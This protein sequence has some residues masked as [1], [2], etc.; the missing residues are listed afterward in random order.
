MNKKKGII[1]KMQQDIIIFAALNFLVLIFS[2]LN[3]NFIDRYNIMSMVQSFV[4]Y[5]IM[6][7]G[8]T[9][10]VA[11]GGIDLSIGT[12]CIAS[13]VI[14]GK[15][16]MSGMPLGLTI[17]VMIL[18]GLIFGIINGLMVSRLKLPAFIATLGTMMIARGASALIAKNPNIF[19]PTGTWYN[20]VFSNA[21][22][23]PIGIIWVL[24]FMMLG[25]Y[26][27]YKTKV[28]RYILAIGSN[29]EA[30]NLSGINTKKYK[31][32]AYILSGICAGIAGIFW[33]SSF[34]TIVIGSGNG[35]ELDVIAG[36]Y[37]GGTSATGGNASILGSVIGSFML[38]VIRSGLNFVL[39]KFNI[40]MNSTYVT[41]VL[42]GI[43]VVVAVILDMIKKRKPASVKKA[44]SKK[45][46][47]ILA[48]IASVLIIAIIVSTIIVFGNSNKDKVIAIVA[49]GETHAFWQ[50]VEKGAQDAATKYGYKITFR[51]PPSE[52]PANLPI[53]FEMV[54]TGLSNGSKG[55]VLSC[56]GEGFTD[57][58]KQ[59]YKT[60]IP[61]VSF[62]SG[63]WENDVKTL[64]ESNS[65]PIVSTVVNDN[66]SAAG[67]AAEHLFEEIKDKIASSA[68]YKVGVIQYDESSAAY[69]RA[70]GFTDKLLQLV[71]ED[72]STKGRLTIEREIKPG[73]DN[74]A[75]V[76]ALDA[77]Y[78]KGCKAIF[79]SSEPVVYQVYNAIQSIGNK[80]D[81]LTFVGFDA[82]SKQIEWMKSETKPIL[83]GSVAQN[84]YMIGY[85]ATEQVILAIEGGKT[86]ETILIP[87]IWWN[88]ENMQE[89]IES[90]IVYEG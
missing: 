44:T 75:Y 72:P 67:I 65:N 4:P 13:T 26:L 37:V 33:S 27:M 45:K 23:F 63:V 50:A 19:Y 49:K 18:V 11:T 39:A 10:V 80:Y 29:E 5:V 6:A 41:Y 51:G 87:G 32:I 9:F 85:N 47:I 2:L 31:M 7:I 48:I 84:S 66:Y 21:N 36:I 58:L 70:N 88:K 69:N 55:L 20:S 15:L 52:T 25:I 56:I 30:A 8:T 68:N 57:L 60:G 71:E 90:G 40:D 16:Y 43:I 83:I 78:E 12:V 35:M 59:A 82:G 73:E 89:E 77:L 86:S 62:D 53:Q 54:Q 3:P 46:K 14:A 79:L 38:V 76:D 34:A 28:G 61:V 24:G 1:E 74:N 17:I 22:G 42:T 64:N 81:E